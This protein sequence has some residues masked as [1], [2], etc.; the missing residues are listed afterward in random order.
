MKK[1]FGIV[2]LFFCVFLASCG[3][4]NLSG[5]T[6]SLEFS[7]PESA[8]IKLGSQYSARSIDADLEDT[9]FVFLVQVKG[10]KNYYACQQS[11]LGYTKDKLEEIFEEMRENKNSQS[12]DTRPASGNDAADYNN[13]EFSEEFKYL[14]REKIGDVKFEF[15]NLPV[16][17]TYTVMFDL[18]VKPMPDDSYNYST[19]IM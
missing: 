4:N 1:L 16:N 6:G 8:I 9:E 11:Y 3:F 7:I 13:E 18:L 2:S 19:Y 14:F 17:Q 5:K 12:D 15:K 10:S